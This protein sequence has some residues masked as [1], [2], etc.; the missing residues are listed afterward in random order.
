MYYHLSSYNCTVAIIILILFGRKLKL[1]EIKQQ[2][3]VCAQS[4]LHA[5]SRNAVS[6]FCISGSICQFV[7][8]LVCV[9]VCV[10]VCVQSLS[11]VQLF[12]TSQ[13]VARQ[14]PP[15][16]GL[17]QARLLQW[18]AISFSRDLPDPGVQAG[19]SHL[20]SLEVEEILILLLCKDGGK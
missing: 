10:C 5:S 6:F 2:S 16:L 18:V 4:S 8:F 11:H 15:I 3:C 20:G 14:G 12:A 9:C 7:K 13:N 1:K 17:F 19:S